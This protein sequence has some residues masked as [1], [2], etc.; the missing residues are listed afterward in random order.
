MNVSHLVLSLAL[1][2]CVAGAEVPRV[3]TLSVGQWPEDLVF[4]PGSGHLFV[5][6][7]GSATVTVLN[8]I[9][10]RVGMIR[11]VSRA[12]HLAVDS[13]LGH[14]YVPNEGN[15]FVAVFDTRDLTER[16]VV[17]SRRS[18]SAAAPRISGSTPRRGSSTF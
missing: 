13:A 5:A 14:V 8:A 18:P 16:A 1:A 15:G 7:E 12:R 6:D 9:G 4:D 17:G 11:L 2:G 3:T 10:E